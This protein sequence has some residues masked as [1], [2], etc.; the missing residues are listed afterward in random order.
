MKLKHACFVLLCLGANGMEA[1][2]LPDTRGICDLLKKEYE[3]VKDT[4]IDF[5]FFDIDHDGV[6]DA[7]VSWRDHRSGTGGVGNGWALYRF[8]NGEWIQSPFKKMDDGSCD[9]SNDVFGRFDSFHSLTRDGQPPKLICVFKFYS[10]EFDGMRIME[11]AHEVTIDGEGYL[12]AIPV[13]E[14]MM[15]YDA[16]YDETKGDY[17]FPD[18]GDDYYALKKQLVPLPT[19]TVIPNEAQKPDTDTPATAGVSADEDDKANV[20]LPTPSGKSETKNPAVTNADGKGEEQGS[21]PNRWPYLAILP[22][23]LAVFYFLRKKFSKN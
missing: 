5:L 19:E 4:P 3:T 16:P 11:Y 7:L 8:E 14:L 23:I 2:P 18:L 10:K 20:S 13:P 12:K 21:P 17:I 15:E 6:V 1:Q 22:L 9:P